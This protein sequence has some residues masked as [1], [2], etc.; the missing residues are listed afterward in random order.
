MQFPS[1][2]LPAESFLLWIS[3]LSIYLFFFFYVMYVI[4]R[5]RI[6][7]ILVQAEMG[8]S[9]WYKCCKQ[10]YFFYFIFCLKK[11]EIFYLYKIHNIHISME[12]NLS[13]FVVSN[14]YN[15]YVCLV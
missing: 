4:D 9:L 2:I 12:I 1:G 13:R 7:I 11:E 14:I 10:F 15:K 8:Y 3:D 6:K 5:C